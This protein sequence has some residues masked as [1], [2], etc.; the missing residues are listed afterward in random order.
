MKRISFTLGLLLFSILAVSQGLK[1]K[2]VIIVTLDG[3]RW[4]EVFEGADSSILFNADYVHD[5]KVKNQFWDKTPEERRNKLFPFLWNTIGVQG[6]LYGN[7][8][9]ES[10]V[11]CSNPYF[12]SYPGYSEMLTGMVDLDVNSN[13]KIENPNYTVLEFINDQKLY[14]NKVAAFT[15]WDVFPYILREEASGIPV[16]AGKESTTGMLSEKEVMLNELQELIQN[17]HG[18]RYD[19]FTF[20]LA[21][22]YLNR[23]RPNVLFI[24][25]DET[26][27][28]T[29]KGKYDEYL[30][31]AHK[32]DI[33]LAKLWDWIQSQ[34]DYKD[35]T[36]LLITTDHGRGKR[37]KKGWTHHGLHVIGS[38]QIWLAA[39]GPDTP[40]LGEIRFPYQVYQKQIAKTIAAFLGLNF[41][42]DKPVGE[43][44]DLL[45][46]TPELEASTKSEVVW[47][48]H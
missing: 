44:I 12:F 15:T 10:D 33:M 20:Y 7:R 45:F 34:P 2:N 32:T 24:S 28:Y 27:E 29:H 39:I 6:Q 21:M 4:Q 36:T 38:G 31:S 8:N 17:P 25:L 14:E 9:Y 16:N 42:Q 46:I 26:D 35:Q 47:S 41:V 11:N 3:V 1:T 18:S 22:E 23:I 5:Q 37:A 43:A 48:D 40:D 30:K 13:G 19:A